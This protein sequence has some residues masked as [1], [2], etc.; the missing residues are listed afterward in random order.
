MPTAANSGRIFI[1][2][3]MLTETLLSSAL[4]AQ[5]VPLEEVASEMNSIPVIASTTQSVAPNEDLPLRTDP[6][7]QSNITLL[8]HLAGDQRQFWTRPKEFSS[9]DTTEL[10]PFIAFTG[11]L[12]ASDHWITQQ[13]PNQPDQ[14][15]R[16]LHI[17]NYGI[18]ALA[19]AAGG[20]WLWGK[21]VK[22]DHLQESGILS[23]E[24]AINSAAVAYAL[25]AITQRSRPDAST[26]NGFFRGGNSFPSDHSAVA[27]SLASVLAHEYPGPLTQFV[28]YG[29][30]S[31]VTLTRVTSQQHFASD[32]FVGS[33]LGWYLGRQVYRAHHDPELG[34][35]AWSNRAWDDRAWGVRA[36]KAVDWKSHGNRHDASHPWSGSM[37]SPY[38]P[39]DSWVYPAFERLIAMGYM[40]NA[41]LDQ[42]PWTRMECARLLEDAAERLPQNDLAQDSVRKLY[43]ALSEEFAAETRRRDGES[44]DQPDVHAAVD[45]VYTRVT[46]ISG[47]ALDDGFHFG[48]T[49]VNDYGRPYASGVSSMAGFSSE[50]TAGPLAFYVRAEYQQA[51]ASAPYSAAVL[52]ATAQADGRPFMANPDQAISQPDLLESLVALDFHDLQLSFG[53]QS[54]W[55]SPSRSG[56]LLLSNNAS[57]FLMFRI[58][59]TTPYEIPLLSRLLGPARSEFFLGQLS[60]QQFVYNGST[61]IGPR[62]NPQPFLHGD[63]ISFQPSA[64]LE[65]GMGVAVM[66]GGPGLP[67]TWNNFLRTYYLHSTNTTVNPGKRFSAFDFTFRVPGLRK[68]LTFYTDSLVV[69]EFSPIGSSRPSLNPGLCFPQMPRLQKLEIRL[70]GLKTAQAPHVDF[71][72]GYVY[73]DRRY[74]SGYTNNGELLGSWIGRAGIGGQAWT[75]YHLSARNTLEASFRHMEVDHSFL[76]GGH[77]NDFSLESQLQLRSGMILTSRIQYERWAFPLL[78]LQPQRNLTTSLQISFSPRFHTEKGSLAAA[79]MAATGAPGQLWKE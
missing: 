4:V 45:S 10:L 6:E 49:L 61:T 1:L 27:W 67:F 35:G 70:E 31:A 22:D 47:P 26:G 20:S 68:W 14:L 30:A 42:R 59:Q 55:L 28:A 2:L 73:T 44:H 74:L 57:P 79:R 48:Q 39:L 11:L 16:S 43:R 32:A 65:F 75:T 40:E 66:F 8:K 76:E 58:D 71:P 17:S 34:G 51:P 25:S 18:Y 64:N 63:R 56:S 54:A 72:A 60:G 41:Y 62:L 15:K 33:A 12:A 37:A 36:W 77:L 23:V 38:E 9:A 69:D 5:N 46:D 78:A 7:N 53:K 24:A 29:L 3:L 21:I 50:L 19:G 52:Q 13:V